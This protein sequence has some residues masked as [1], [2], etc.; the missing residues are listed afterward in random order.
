MMR[1]VRTEEQAYVVG[2][3][4]RPACSFCAHS[5]HFLHSF[6]LGMFMFTQ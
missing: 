1:C 6:E 5:E 3:S 4:D 2:V